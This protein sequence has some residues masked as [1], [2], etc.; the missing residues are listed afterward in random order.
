[1]KFICD[2]SAERCNLGEIYRNCRDDDE[3][4]LQVP[5]PHKWLAQEMAS[6]I[7]E[8]LKSVRRKVEV[9]IELLP[10]PITE[11]DQQEQAQRI[12]QRI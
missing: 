8:H 12:A 4:V 2:L 11:A 7:R 5:E 3:I 1:M 9:L 6:N 10:C